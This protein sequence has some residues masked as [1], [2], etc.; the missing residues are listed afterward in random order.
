M[1]TTAPVE[2]RKIIATLVKDTLLDG[3]DTEHEHAVFHLPW[4]DIGPPYNLILNGVVWCIQPWEIPEN[5][6]SY[7]VIYRPAGKHSYVDITGMEPV[8]IVSNRR[9]AA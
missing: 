6:K 9:L 5:G 2:T 1:N 3:S 8:K 4:A 7:N